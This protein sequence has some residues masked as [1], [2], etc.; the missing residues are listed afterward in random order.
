[1]NS[2]NLTHSLLSDRVALVL[3]VIVFG[4]NFIVPAVGAIQTPVNFQRLVIEAGGHQAIIRKL[5]FT[6]DGTELVSIADDKTIRVWSVSGDGRKSKLIRTIRGQIEDGR[7]GQLF[8]AALSPPDSSGHQKWL[9]VG[10]YLAGPSEDRNA[11]RVHDYA[12]GEIQALLKGHTNN[13]ITLAFSPNGRWLASAGKDRNILIWDISALKGTNLTITPLVLKGHTDRITGLAWSKPGDRL[14][15]AS[16]DGTVGLWNTSQ[17]GQEKV[18]LVKRL[19][20]HIGKVR[21]VVFHPKED[22]LISGGAGSE[23]STLEG[24]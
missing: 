13:I 5:L 23:N 3:A 24:E 12:T 19:E 7:S 17:L 22:F 8:A 11:V 15:S 20:G 14:A 18:Y 2:R 16:Y 1:M 21:S 10:G 9:A 4:I 6:A